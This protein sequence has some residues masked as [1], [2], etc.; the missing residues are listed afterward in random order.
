MRTYFPPQKHPPPIYSSSGRIPE[1][2]SAPI[3]FR[4]A[5]LFLDSLRVPVVGIIIGQPDCCSPHFINFQSDEMYPEWPGGSETDIT[6]SSLCSRK[7][8]YAFEVFKLYHKAPTAG[9]WEKDY[10]CAPALINAETSSS[11][12][13]LNSS[14]VPSLR[15]FPSQAS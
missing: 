8:S 6:S 7:T 12:L 10:F 4:G 5:L 11:A 3:I 15:I 2:Q 14:R 9:Q 13:L 1:N